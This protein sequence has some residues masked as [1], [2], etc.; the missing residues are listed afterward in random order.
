MDKE[1]VMDIIGT[2]LNIATRGR[3]EAMGDTPVDKLMSCEQ[4]QKLN[5]TKEALIEAFHQDTRVTAVACE[6]GRFHVITN[7]GTISFNFVCGD[8]PRFVLEDKSAC[9]QP[10][11]DRIS[12][13]KRWQEF[14]LTYVNRELRWRT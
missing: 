3:L 5:L 12:A 13:M 14:F 11:T 10:V 2:S 9:E 8:D 1:T 4:V 6:E 7:E